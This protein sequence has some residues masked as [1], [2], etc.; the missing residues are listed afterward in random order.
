MAQ[1]VGME[2]ER[3]F[4]ELNEDVEADYFSVVIVKEQ[5]E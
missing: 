4:H 5:G 2:G 1:R 3:L